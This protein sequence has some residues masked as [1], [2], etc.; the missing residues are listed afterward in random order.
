MDYSNIAESVAKLSHPSIVKAI[1]QALLQ[2]IREIKQDLHS[3]TQ[4]ITATE[5]RISDLEDELHQAQALLNNSDR[6]YQY[7]ADKIEDLENRSHR[8]NL[9]VIGLPE[10]YKLQQLLELCQTDIPKALGI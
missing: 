7:L 8:N 10:S 4:Q 9:R 1:E 3:Q 2:G 5:Q 6:R